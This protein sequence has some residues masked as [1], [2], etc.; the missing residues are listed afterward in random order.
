M[1]PRRDAGAGPSLIKQADAGIVE[2]WKWRRGSAVVARRH[3][4]HRRAATGRPSLPVP[5]RE[6]LLD[7]LA[8]IQH[9]H[10]LRRVINDTIENDLRRGGKRT[11]ASAHLVSRAPGKRM[12]FD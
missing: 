11:Q 8:P 2:A 9:A 4:L 12:A 5:R 6:F 7:V 3:R 10:D 1:I